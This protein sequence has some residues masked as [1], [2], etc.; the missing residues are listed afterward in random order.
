M[1]AFAALLVRT[2]SLSLKVGGGALTGL[3]FFLATVSVFPFGVGPDLNL[4]ARIGP[5]I[6]WITAL[7]ATLLGLDRLFQDDRDDGSLDLLVLAPLS[8]ELQ[9][10]AKAIGHWVATGLPLVIVAPLLGL[11]LNLDPRALLAVTVTLLVGTP[12]LTLIGTIGSALMVALRRG[13]MLISV[14][15]LPF[16]IPVLIFGVL[17]TNAVLSATDEFLPPFLILLA[18]NLFALVVAPV[19]G[20]AAIRTALD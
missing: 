20:A 13:G 6:L 5:A 8:L 1:S 16:T 10:L 18:L 17:A 2:I 11:F 15:I 9:V 19:A 4:L 3:L 7:L 12:A 14:L